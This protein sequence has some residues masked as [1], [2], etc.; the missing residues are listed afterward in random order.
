MNQARKSPC[1]R[2]YN[3]FGI[4]VVDNAH[5]TSTMINTLAVRKHNAK[6]KFTTLTLI[7]GVGV[8][9]HVLYYIVSYLYVRCSSWGR[10]SYFFCYRLL[11]I[12]CFLLRGV[13]SSSW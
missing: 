8:S 7:I 9:C 2:K 1:I 11:L 6:I 3:R 5:T 4:Y 12:M 13:S 10:E